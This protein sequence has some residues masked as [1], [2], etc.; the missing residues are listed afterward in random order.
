MKNFQTLVVGWSVSTRVT[1]PVCW[2]ASSSSWQAYEAGLE[3]MREKEGW[4]EGEIDGGR[5]GG[6]EG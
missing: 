6:K 3:R 2:N 1:H 4:M 5:G